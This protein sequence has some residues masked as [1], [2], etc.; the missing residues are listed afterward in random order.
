MLH[1]RHVMADVVQT[2]ALTGTWVEA[3]I[4]NGKKKNHWHFLGHLSP[5]HPPDYE[6]MEMN[7]ASH[8]WKR[9]QT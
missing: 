9:Q 6:H 7:P 1:Y 3:A 8:G 5:P 4:F 2:Q